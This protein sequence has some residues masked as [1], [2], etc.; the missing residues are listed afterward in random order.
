MTWSMFFSWLIEAPLDLGSS[1]ICRVLAPFVVPFANGSR[2]PEKFA[3]METHD[4]DLDGDEG[5][6]TEHVV[7]LNVQS[8]DSLIT[9]ALKRWAK[10]TLWLW[11]NAAYRYKYDVL[12]AYLPH[13]Q[14]PAI[15]GDIR[16]SDRPGHAGSLLIICGVYWEYYAVI[17][18]LS[19]RC[20]RLRFGWKLKGHAE[21]WLRGERHDDR[22]MRVQY[23]NPVKTFVVK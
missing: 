13:W 12:G 21:A 6:K 18:Y 3:W 9:A 16:T 14:T 20:V 7:W 5:W 19:D 2:L 22:A 23:I 1:V 11:R 10:R 17:P 8:G 4:N 15:S